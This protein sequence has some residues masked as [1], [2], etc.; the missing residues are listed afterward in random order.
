MKLVGKKEDGYKL[1]TS[2]PKGEVKEDPKGSKK[3]N[4]SKKETDVANTTA[5]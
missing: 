4:S 3:N 1:T 5:E 2:F